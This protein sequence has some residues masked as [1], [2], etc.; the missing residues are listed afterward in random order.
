[1]IDRAQLKLKK[2]HFFFDAQ[3]KYFM[4]GKV[5]YTYTQLLLNCSQKLEF[6]LFYQIHLSSQVKRSVIISNKHGV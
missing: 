1:M 2:I 5:K 6:L 4:S 3:N